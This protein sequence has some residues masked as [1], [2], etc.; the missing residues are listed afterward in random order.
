M[1]KIL[2]IHPGNH[3]K[4][5][6]ELSGLYSAVAPPVWTALL[7]D[8]VRS[9][10]I[11]CAIYDT[12]VYGWSQTQCKDMLEKHNPELI[13]M[14]V[15]GHNPSA[16]TQT[17]PVASAIAS[18]IKSF[19]NDL[20]LA[21]GGL[22]PSALPE[23]TLNEESCDYVLRGEGAIPIYNLYS[24]IN[25]NL[26]RSKLGGVSY[27]EKSGSFFDGGLPP[28]T[29]VLDS[30]YQ[31]YAFDLLPSLNSYRAHNSHCFQDFEKSNEPG[32][33]D[34]RSPYFVLY[35]SLG[36]PYHCTYCCINSLFGKPRIRYWN[37]E[38]VIEWIDVLVMKY[39]IK[40][41]RLDDELFILSPKR[42]ERF[43]DMLIE[44]GYNLNLWAYARVDTINTPLLK[45]M[46][47]AGLNW[48]CLGIEA[49]AAKVRDN[50]GKIINKD[51]FNTVR[52]IQK[53]DIYVL[54]NFMFGLPEDNLETMRTTL[55]AAIRLRCEFVNFNCTMAYPGS[56]L[57][58]QCIKTAPDKL[59]DSWDGYTQHGYET[60]PLP[61]KYLTSEQVLKF[62]D[63]AF[64]QYYSDTE[65]LNFMRQRF[66][67][68]TADHIIDMTRIR[69][70]RK[71][72]GN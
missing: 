67:N 32:F 2:F 61:T 33:M 35:T 29:E 66:G 1:S 9:Q 12:N 52:T 57:Y 15:Y 56:Q 6:Q 21:M 43:C 8:Y 30:T 18:D 47:R 17:M 58:D 49:G 45:K 34:V 59:P 40:N 51:I 27:F 64:I 42:V 4:T 13:V 69:L 22:H 20:P 68:K 39:R 23:K 25:G 50:V 38:T 60:Q 65:Y 71:I 16:S 14:M 72:L 37:L 19:N 28:M 53:N 44:R 10:G 36:C 54:G 48:L 7:A 5:Y 41:I 24:Y 31:S 70:K 55:E 26:P 63:E 62:R 46:K 11:E 3:K